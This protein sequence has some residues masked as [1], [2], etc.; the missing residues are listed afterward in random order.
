MRLRVLAGIL[1]WLVGLQGARAQQ[2]SDTPRQVLD[3]AAQLQAKGDSKGA[4]R[5]LKA[6]R[7]AHRNHER[8]HH[9]LA[10][11]YYQDGNAFWASVDPRPTSQL[12]SCPGDIG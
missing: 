7:D 9:A 1:A 5:E 4:I 12:R 2:P 11:A 3:R 6:G 8:I 10:L